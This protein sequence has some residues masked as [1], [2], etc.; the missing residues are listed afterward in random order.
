LKKND[1]L[2]DVRPPKASFFSKIRAHLP[3]LVLWVGICLT[4][5]FNGYFDKLSGSAAVLATLASVLSRNKIVFWILLLTILLSLAGFIS[6]FPGRLFIIIPLD[7]LSVTALLFLLYIQED[8]VKEILGPYLD[9]QQD[10][11]QNAHYNFY[12]Q[13]FRT[14]SSEEL[15]AIMS[16]EGMSEAAK[17]AARDLLSEE[18]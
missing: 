7:A 16:T 6:I 12:L 18:E 14:K 3:L 4:I 9:V 13:R 11:A 8:Y 17:A 1:I 2:D 10:D 15:K 5:L